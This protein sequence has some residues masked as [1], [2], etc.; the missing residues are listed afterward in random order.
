MHFDKLTLSQASIEVHFPCGN[1][2]VTF[3]WKIGHTG[4]WTNSLFLSVRKWKFTLV[5][6]GYHYM[7]MTQAYLLDNACAGVLVAGDVKLPSS[8]CSEACTELQPPTS[9]LQPAPA[10][11]HHNTNPPVQYSTVQYST[12]QYHNTN[13]PPDFLPSPGQYTVEARNMHIT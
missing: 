2:N 5:E 7:T 1:V 8:R 10:A 3:D 9:S 13:P 11:P 4:F 6:S 12:V